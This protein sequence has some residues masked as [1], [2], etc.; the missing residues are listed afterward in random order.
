[1]KLLNYTS[2]YLAIAILLIVSVWGTIFYFIM[3]KDVKS[4]VDSGLVNSKY[5]I[6]KNAKTNPTVLSKEIFH[7]NNYTIHT[8]HAENKRR[9]KD[10]FQDTT[11]ALQNG[12]R[13]EPVRMLKTQFTHHHQA[14]ELKIVAS[15]VAEDKL[16]S[17]LVKGLLGLYAAIIIS[18]FI[19]QQLLVRKI[20][21]PFR[22]LLDRLRNFQLDKNQHI[23]PIT[24]PISEFQEMNEVITLQM[25]QLLQTYHSQKQFLENA[26]HEL[27]TP[28]AISINRLEL[29]LEEDVA[30]EHRTH[31]V[32]VIRTLERLNRLNASLL[33]LTKIENQQF[34]QK[35]PVSINN[36][37]TYLLSEFEDLIEQKDLHVSLID[38]VELQWLMNRDLAMILVSNLLKNAIVHNKRGGKIRIHIQE[39]AFTIGN[40]SDSASLDP[41]QIFERFK[42]QGKNKTS[43]GLGLA[44]CKAIVQTHRLKLSY[45][46][47]IH[48]Q[49]TVSA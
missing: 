21:L 22:Q 48:Q 40:D 46:F 41:N 28:L 47:Q 37:F 3:L 23:T 8:I 39:N 4:E 5:L 19:V 1:M 11:R 34:T 6:I 45:R 36:I 31:I 2:F 14:Y 17:S 24:T 33:L 38:K 42:N 29:L 12:Q 35:T 20:W 9:T 25:E 16:I 13:Y 18:S 7:G 30:N 27:Q 49:F 10:R 44:I 43:I 15:M 26:A 32:R